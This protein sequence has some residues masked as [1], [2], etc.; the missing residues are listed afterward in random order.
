MQVACDRVQLRTLGYSRAPR[1]SLAQTRR[2]G[3][4]CR[5]AR[6][7]ACGGAACPAGAPGAGRA[8]PSQERKGAAPLPQPLHRSREESP[9]TPAASAAARG[10]G[11]GPTARGAGTAALQTR[12]D[13]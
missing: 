3:R 7:A 9:C 1:R 13:R 11:T 12:E 8:R 5:C 10:A 4:K 2:G 6:K